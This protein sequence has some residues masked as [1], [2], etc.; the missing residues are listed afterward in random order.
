MAEL[1]PI[2]I[3]IVDDEVLIAED[4]KEICEEAGYTV[5]G[6][7]YRFSQAISVIDREE[8]DLAIF[9]INLE[10]EL[11]GLDLALHIK[12][13]KINLP[14]IF[15]TSYSDQTTL[16]AAKEVQP[17]GYV[18]KPFQ[19]EQLISTIEISIANYNSYKNSNLL[20]IDDVE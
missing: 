3:L 1:N 19:K 10:D 7:C 14:Y 12:Q 8:F 6:I 16:N 13:K 9:D 11:S 5:G 15:L 4:I 2:K 20:S 18:V 17:L